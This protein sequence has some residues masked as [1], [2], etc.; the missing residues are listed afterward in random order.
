M[1]SCD[2]YAA[3]IQLY[4][5]KE[6]S[7]QELEE[8]RAHLTTCV[9]CQE[10]LAAEEELSS[11]LYRSRP[12]Y[13]ASDAL[14]DR[15]HQAT[16]GITPS[17]NG[18]PGNLRNNILG[19]MRQPADYSGRRWQALAAMVLVICLGL[20]F[21]PGIVQRVRASSYVDMAIATHRSFVDGSLPLEVQSDSPTAVA[22]W[23]TGKVPFKFRLPSSGEATGQDGS[24]KL[25]GGRLVSYQSGYA[26]L[27]SYRMQQQIISL[28]ITSDKFAGAAGGEVVRSGGITF[29]HNRRASLNIIT[30]SNHG[31][32]YALVSS[33]PGSGK[34]S[35]LVCHENMADSRQFAARR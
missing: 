4:L 14:R 8:F 12:L 6:L 23:F 13:S 33:L 16:I 17:G 31:L 35:C 3:N 1:K 25:I 15:V 5:D 24:Y 21:V 20:A 11:L 22:A 32:T 27:V 7:G 18:A 29:H 10:E 30:W 34:Q 28:L 9:S 19:M 2:E 26:A